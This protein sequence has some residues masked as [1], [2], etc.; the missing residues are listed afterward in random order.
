MLA[1]IS[2]LRGE[3]LSLYHPDTLILLIEPNIINVN[4]MKNN[5][6]TFTHVPKNENT[7]NEINNIQSIYEQIDSKHY[8]VM[9]IFYQELIIIF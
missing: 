8:F 5:K 2:Q 1:D 4:S 6:K 3:Q 7:K 9:I